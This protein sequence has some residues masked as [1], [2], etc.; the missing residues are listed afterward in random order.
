MKLYLKTYFC[1]YAFICQDKRKN[2]GFQDYGGCICNLNVCV[3]LAY[4]ADPVAG[5]QQAAPEVRQWFTAQTRALT[6][7][8]G[9]FPNAFF[10]SLFVNS[11]TARNKSLLVWLGVHSPKLGRFKK[12]SSDSSQENKSARGRKSLSPEK[13]YPCLISIQYGVLWVRRKFV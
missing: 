8:V 6:E 11:A 1:F 4:D 2:R 9:A 5:G 3:F 13:F 12:F 7:S 10:S